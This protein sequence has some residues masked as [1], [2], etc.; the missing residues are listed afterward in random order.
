MYVGQYIIHAGLILIPARHI[1]HGSVSTE[2]GGL[3]QKVGISLGG[4][5]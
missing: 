3:R 4:A 2:G 5:Y 1:G